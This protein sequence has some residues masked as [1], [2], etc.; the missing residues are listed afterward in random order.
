M[1][2]IKDLIIK[3]LGGWTEDEYKHIY[4]VANHPFIEKKE[5]KLVKLRTTVMASGLLGPDLL[6]DRARL[7]ELIMEQLVD[8]I[9]PV[10]EHTYSRNDKDGSEVH[11]FDA[12][13]ELPTKYVTFSDFEWED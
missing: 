9:S 12:Y 6:K 3:K 11:R 10:V 5:V 13:I 4:S 7:N 8:R 2:K 1:G